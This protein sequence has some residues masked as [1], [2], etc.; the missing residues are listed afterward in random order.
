MNKCKDCCHYDDS[1]SYP[2][3]G[4]CHLYDTYTKADDNCEDWEERE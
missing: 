4:Y 2:D 3:A 1:Q